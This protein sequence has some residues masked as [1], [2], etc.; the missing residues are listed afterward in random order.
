MVSTPRHVLARGVL[1]G[2]ALVA[3][4][5]DLEGGASVID[6]PRVLAIKSEPAEAAPKGTLPATITWSALYV[7]PDGDEDPAKLDWGLCIQRKPLATA[8]EISPACLVP[9]ADDP[10]L[11]SLVPLG[12]GASVMGLLP[13][14]GCRQFGPNPPLP[15]A[16]EPAPRPTD[17]DATGGFYQ[18]LRVAADEP[19]GYEY[20]VGL[21]R[22]SCGIA[23]VSA[24]QVI[25][26]QNRYRANTNPTL[27][28]VVVGPGRDDAPLTDDPET[29]ASVK[30]GSHVTLRASWPSCPTT[31]ECG[32]GDCEANEDKTSC[33]E[34]CKDNPHGCAGSEPYIA[35]D[36]G[37]RELVERREGMRVSWYATGGAFDHD[38]SGRAESGAAVPYSDNTWV[39]P[40]RAADVRLWAVLRDERGGVDYA[41]YFVRVE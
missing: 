25:D 14:D 41:S 39:A 29:T 1:F 15:K 40:S 37:L 30:P 26:Y 27:L 31:P 9:L 11:E 34:D 21:T 8:G 17:P 28:G 22:I 36:L 7:G 2:L 4:K 20:S 38:R 5:P 13:D 23:R 24:D 12:E 16:G 10:L 33:P 3:C 35:F 18:P 6:A 19:G 32:N